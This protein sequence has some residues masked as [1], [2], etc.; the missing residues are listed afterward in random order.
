MCF[1]RAMIQTLRLSTAG[2]RSTYC[3]V[4][5][6]PVIV[7]FVM[8]IPRWLLPTFG[9]LDDGYTLRGTREM[10]R[11]WT[12]VLALASSGRF[13]P[14]HWFFYATVHAVVGAS[15]L[16]FFI[17]NYV[18]LCGIA[19]G[20]AVYMVRAGAHHVQ[21][22]AAALFLILSGPA[23]ESF[24]TLS[25]AE[26]P[27]LLWLTASLLVMSTYVHASTVW[28]KTLSGLGMFI[29]LL[30]A[31]ATKETSVAMV[32]IAVAWAGLAWWHRHRTGG[33]D[34]LAGRAVYGVA[35]VAAASAFFGLR[36]WA[37]GPHLTGGWY[38]MRYRLEG[39]TLIRALTY[40]G[41]LLPR[42]FAYVVP[43][44]IFVAAVSAVKRWHPQG[45]VLEAIAWMA[46]WLAV[47]LPW[48]WAVDYYLLPF[49]FGCVTVGA[50]LLGDVVDMART[51]RG[52]MRAGAI[53][54]LAVTAALWLLNLLTPVSN[55]SAQLTV[56]AANADM[57]RFLATL[58]PNSVVMVN[59]DKD[60]EY[61]S[62]LPLHLADLHGR[63][64]VTVEAFTPD[65]A[66][67]SHSASAY[68][69]TPEMAGAPYP[70]VRPPFNEDRVRS[71]TQ[72]LHQHALWTSDL[73]YETRHRVKVLEVGFDRLVC[74][75]IAPWQAGGP[76]CKLTGPIVERRVFS[77]GWKLYRLR[78]EVAG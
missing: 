57:V 68:I 25:K 46:G 47:Y 60:H 44:V 1:S 38:T 10:G 5:V 77:Y 30:V 71:W 75:V 4:L 17:V 51:T 9:L 73:V 49:T 56:D 63:P 31:D 32:P 16:G 64:D 74:P 33:D 42:D 41:G 50:V 39:A 43:L 76:L 7:A 65:K 48:G 24:Y 55:A 52:G 58:P 28:T 62:E 72:A 22:L 66:L 14:A 78:A 29:P 2:P 45:L 40:W 11:V 6:V 70:S 13:M 35:A 69:M 8:M 36:A 26:P 15:P 19:V 59:I 67:G 18:M 3:I 20:L 37:I 34:R 54:T 21:A 27:Q 53:A 23:V 61:L 12:G